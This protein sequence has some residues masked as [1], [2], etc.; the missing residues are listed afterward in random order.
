M[1][2]GLLC[3]FGCFFVFF[4]VVSDFL[5]FSGV[6]CYILLF[7]VVR[8]IGASV[9]EFGFSVGFIWVLGA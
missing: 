6:F 9:W 3:Q 2:N 1:L 7:C 8:G 4:L 5:L